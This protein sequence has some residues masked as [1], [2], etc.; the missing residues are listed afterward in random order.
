VQSAFLEKV[1][2]V[3]GGSGA[4]RGGKFTVGWT[5]GLLLVENSMTHQGVTELHT[6]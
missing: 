3:G 4:V 6:D 2:A 5:T 1:P